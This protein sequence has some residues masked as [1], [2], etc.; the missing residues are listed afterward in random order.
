M[1]GQAFYRDERPVPAGA[2]RGGCADCDAYQALDATDAPLYR[3][4]VH[5]D[6]TCPALHDDTRE[7]S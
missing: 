1:N 6:P 5:H 3:L 2:V 4:T 7:A